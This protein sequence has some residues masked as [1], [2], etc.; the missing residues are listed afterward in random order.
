MR[1]REWPCFPHLLHDPKG[2][3][4]AGHVVV[5]NLSPV[6]AYDE[7]AVQDAKRNCRYREEVHG[8]NGLAM[9]LQECQPAFAQ[10]GSPGIRC[11][12]R[13]TV[14]SETWKPSFSSSP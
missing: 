14:G 12:H 10:F 4:I 13:D 9:V 5:Q 1:G 11:S 2:T 3:R 6:V 7:E 8:G